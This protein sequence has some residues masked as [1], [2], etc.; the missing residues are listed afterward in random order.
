MNTGV[1]TVMAPSPSEKRPVLVVY[2]GRSSEHEVSCRS[3]AF[4]LRNLDTRK[5]DIHALAIDKQGRWLPQD[6]GKLLA[7]IEAGA[8]TVPIE[9]GAGA[10]SA[11]P[12]TADPGSSLLALTG[13]SA[14]AKRPPRKE[15]LVVFPILH[16]TFGEDGTM[17]GML[18]LAEVA[19]V[20]PDTLGSAV[21]MDKGVSKKLAQAAGVPVVPWLETR[22]Q[23]WGEHRARIVAE[24][25]AEL[26]YPMF[27]KP[28]RQGSSVGVSKARTRAELE[29]ACDAAFKFD[30]KLLIEKG[31]TVR[32]IECAVLGDYDPMVSVPGEV[33]PHAEFYSYEAKYIDADGAS[34]AIPAKLTPEQTRT[35]QDLAKRVFQALELYGM[36]RVDLFLDKATGAFYLNEVNTIPG[37]TE[38]SQYPLLW[39]ES[40]VSAAELL[41]RLIELAVRRRTAQAGL[42]RSR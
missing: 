3:A 36:A 16:G 15:D 7:G 14:G 1:S 22:A 35:A 13:D 33:I 21:G 29:A 24:A 30:D 26:G 4:I 31:L 5:Y 34:M 38:I 2:G 42:Q 40:G 9:A 23:F 6:A 27:V 8:K 18:D 12:A 32:E 17:Q 10:R 20:G 28:A 39:K 37:F 25:E 11:L 41:D 19:Y